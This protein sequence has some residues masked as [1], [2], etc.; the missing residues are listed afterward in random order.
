M[1]L[2]VVCAHRWPEDYRDNVVS[3]VGG[4]LVDQFETIADG[5]EPDVERLEVEAEYA[6]ALY[7][8]AKARA[9]VKRQRQARH[10]A[11]ATARARQ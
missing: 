1:A 3:R 4:I 10:V 9:V 8:A 7:V 5:S 11:Q 6:L 2:E